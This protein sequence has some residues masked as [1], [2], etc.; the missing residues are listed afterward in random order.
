LPK[1]WSK[2]I[3]QSR[4]KHCGGRY[5]PGWRS[6][7][8]GYEQGGGCRLLSGGATQPAMTYRHGTPQRG[9]PQVPGRAPPRWDLVPRGAAAQGREAGSPRRSQSWPRGS[10]CRRV[11]AAPRR[12][13]Y[14]LLGSRASRFFYQSRNMVGRP[15]R[16]IDGCDELCSRWACRR[17]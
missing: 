17:S 16:K 6:I 13:R 3:K 9:R 14:L 10:G 12:P 4:G 2:Q 5:L 7:V 8:S 15:I 1:Q 11:P